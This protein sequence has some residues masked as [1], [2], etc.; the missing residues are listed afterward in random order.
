[1]KYRNELEDLDKAEGYLFVVMWKLKKR[2][3]KIPWEVFRDI[4]VPNA[5]KKYDIDP[6]EFLLYI[7]SYDY[8]SEDLIKPF[9]IDVDNLDI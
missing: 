4:I 6:K 8:Y 2:I 9:I 1:M 5:L 7:K 3:G